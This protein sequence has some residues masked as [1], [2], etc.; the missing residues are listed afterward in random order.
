M[1]VNENEMRFFQEVYLDGLRIRYI[2]ESRHSPYKY[3]IEYHDGGELVDIS[4]TDSEP[5]ILSEARAF[6]GKW[7]DDARHSDKAFFILRL[8]SIKI[9]FVFD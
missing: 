5:D 1:K 6:F 9:C 2:D 3:A 8:A 7:Y 4:K